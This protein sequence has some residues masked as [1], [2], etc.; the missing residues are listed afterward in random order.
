MA[1][2]RS[3]LLAV[4]VL[5]FGCG[6]AGRG[7]QVDAQDVGP[8]ETAAIA[9]DSVADV[10][11]RGRESADME[12][13]ESETG[14]PAEVNLPFEDAADLAGELEVITD[15]GEE[16]PDVVETGEDAADAADAPGEEVSTPAGIWTDPESGLVWQKS[17]PYVAMYRAA[18]QAHCAELTLAG[19]GWHLPTVEEL[20]TLIRGCPATVPG[21]SCN[22]DSGDCLLWECRDD[23]CTGCAFYG[24]GGKGGCYWPEELGGMCASY[25]SSS[26]VED[27]PE[28]AWH[29]GFQGAYV[30][31]TYVTALTH[32]RCVR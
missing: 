26:D 8:D 25:W 9:S 30:S 27:K 11:D 7:G 6:D 31:P 14:H 5:V 32:V 1:V 2:F 18:A 15:A 12:A 16:I 23:S 24:G 3:V 29:V 10:E 21:G 19:G 28:L 22:V 20:R 13:D 17:A 4:L